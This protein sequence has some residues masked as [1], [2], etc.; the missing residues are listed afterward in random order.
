MRITAERWSRMYQIL[1][2]I[3][4]NYYENLDTT[5][6]GITNYLRKAKLKVDINIVNSSIRHYRKSGLIRRKHNPY[7]RSFQYVLTKKGGSVLISALNE[8]WIKRFS[9]L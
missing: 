9:N 8:R 6:R 7:K 4:I 2:A 1:T 3:E 5:V